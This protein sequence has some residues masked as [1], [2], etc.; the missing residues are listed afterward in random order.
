MIR[1]RP[2]R[3][4]CYTP[5]RRMP[6]GA[7]PHVGLSGYTPKGRG[8]AHGAVPDVSGIVTRWRIGSG[9]QRIG[10]RD[11]E[12]G[13]G[14]NGSSAERTRRGPES[15]VRFPKP[16]DESLRGR[17]RLRREQPRVRA[18]TGLG[19]VAGRPAAL[20]KRA[21]KVPGGRADARWVPASVRLGMASCRMRGGA[22]GSAAGSAESIAERTIR[23]PRQRSGPASDDRPAV[24]SDLHAPSTRVTGR[25]RRSLIPAS[26][27]W[28][29]VLSVSVYRPQLSVEHPA[30]R[31]D[32]HCPAP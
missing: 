28:G 15:T 20:T 11:D 19:E 13:F 24:S 8:S 26:A 14:A 5:R 2:G 1:R 18:S 3:Q 21:A 29:A 12:S 7:E 25:S 9:R 32:Y 16:S 22:D 6:A 10:S 27:S 31:S 4:I 23:G 17:L 30:L